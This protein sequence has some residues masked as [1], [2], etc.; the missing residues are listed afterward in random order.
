MFYGK[1]V[2]LT[3]FKL[4]MFRKHRYEFGASKVETKLKIEGSCRG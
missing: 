4:D 2:K 1:E 3:L